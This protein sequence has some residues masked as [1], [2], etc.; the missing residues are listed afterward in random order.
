M[1]WSLADRIGMEERVV[2]KT[3]R[4]EHFN[5]YYRYDLPKNV[6]P[7]D[8]VNGLFEPVMRNDMQALEEVLKIIGSNT[9]QMVKGRLSAMGFNSESDI[10]EVMQNA[11]EEILKMAFRGFPPKVNADGLFGYLVRVV[12]NCI[13]NYRRQRFFAYNT[14]E[15]SGLENLGENDFEYME[16]A[17]EENVLSLEKMDIEKQVIRYYIKALSDTNKVPYQ[18]ITY[19]YAVLIPQI[20]K[21]TQ[22]MDI[23]NKVNQISGRESGEKTSF[24]EEETNYLGGEIARNSVVLMNWAMDAMYNQSVEFLSREYIELYNREP[25]DGEEFEW[26]NLYKEAMEKLYK[27]TCIRKLVITEEF[28][29]DAIK[30]WPS[31]VITALLKDTEELLYHDTE[32]RQK[33]AGYIEE[34][35]SR[36]VQGCIARIKN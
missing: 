26:G 12:E 30:N 17:P 4:R 11:R 27:N 25:L 20:F 21:R 28:D 31:R 19:C 13:K 6:T 32:F 8:V 9:Y 33:S 36:E 29:K 5:T 35:F 23:L 2:E 7:G 34:L 10:D 24:Y 16:G 14:E 1:C 18:V 3:D 22:N 15:E